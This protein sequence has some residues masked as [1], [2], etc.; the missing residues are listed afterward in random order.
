MHFLF[1]MSLFRVSHTFYFL[2]LWIQVYK[3]KD[4]RKHER[5]KE[6]ATVLWH[7]YYIK[8]NMNTVARTKKA[9]VQP[10]TRTQPARIQEA[11][12]QPWT[13][14]QLPSTLDFGHYPVYIR[15][16][17]YFA[18]VILSALIKNERDFKSLRHEKSTWREKAQKMHACS[19][20]QV[21]D[22]VIALL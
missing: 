12:A 4:D 16:L 14:T 7:C 8:S 6:L 20:I 5:R 18:K 19:R 1:N 13:P 10:G 21:L 22:C 2:F 17:G 15:I 11:I 9:R 3:L